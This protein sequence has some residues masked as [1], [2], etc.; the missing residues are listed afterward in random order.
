MGSRGLSTSLTLNIFLEFKYRAQK[1][2]LPITLKNNGLLTNRKFKTQF[3]FIGRK[4][5]V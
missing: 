3:E 4:P 5:V 1:G 2:Y